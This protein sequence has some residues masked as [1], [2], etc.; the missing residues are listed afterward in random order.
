MD[1]PRAHLAETVLGVWV[2]LTP[3]LS[4]FLVGAGQ[5]FGGASWLELPLHPFFASLYLGVIGGL[6]HL[7]TFKLAAT[8][9]T[10]NW[11]AGIAVGGY[12]AVIA[13]IVVHTLHGVL[14]CC[15]QRMFL[16]LLFFVMLAIPVAYFVTVAVIR[17]RININTADKSPRL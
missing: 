10:V 8:V 3:L 6:I 1:A 15:E 13:Y 17:R 9:V 12:A 16:S 2:L 5:R 14:Q 4:L 11:L 7:L